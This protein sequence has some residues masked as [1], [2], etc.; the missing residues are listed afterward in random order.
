MVEDLLDPGMVD[1]VKGLGRVE[2]EE[3]FFLLVDD[4]R[5]QPCVN[6]DHV[7][8]ALD[9]RKEALLGGVNKGFDSGHDG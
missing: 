8:S 4:G 2:E 5:H 7:V 6:L 3:E 9:A 1:R